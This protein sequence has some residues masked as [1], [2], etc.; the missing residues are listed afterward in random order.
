M[1]K[2]LKIFIGTDG[3]PIT[4][5]NAIFALW[6]KVCHTEKASY[7]IIL[8][9]STYH[10]CYTFEPVESE[11]GVSKLSNEKVPGYTKLYF[12]IGFC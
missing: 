10:G 7:E 2:C 8:E 12:Y 5:L 4:P 3:Y 9:S 11:V 6:K 1:I